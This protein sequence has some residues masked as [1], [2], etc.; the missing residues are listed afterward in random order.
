MVKATDLWNLN[1]PFRLVRLNGSTSWCVLIQGQVRAGL[2][3]VAEIIFEQSAQMVVVEDDHM[4]QALVTN[5]SDH[6]LD[7]AI[8]PRTP[9]CNENLFDA[10]SFDPGCEG[11]AVDSVAVPNHKPGSAVFR[12][13]FDDLLCGPN[14]R[15]MLRNIEVDDAAAIVRQD[16][17]DIDDLQANRCDCEE[18]N[19]YQLPNM[20]SKKG[21]LGLSRL[22]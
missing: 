9:W 2:V 19:G 12:K 22:E 7:I 4:I 17:E 1:D 21:R 8:L 18:I 5:A 15:R 10:H 3:I 20:I 14:R 13:C 6:P 16:N 11:V